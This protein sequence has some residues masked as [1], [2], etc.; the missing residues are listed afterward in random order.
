MN[1]GYLK[2]LETRR[3]QSAKLVPDEPLPSEVVIL[4][5]VETLTGC[6]VARVQRGESAE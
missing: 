5:T 3:G 1:R 6:T 4:P 2:N